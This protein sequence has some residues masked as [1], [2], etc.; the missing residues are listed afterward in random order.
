MIALGENNGIYLIFL[1][2]P[3]HFAFVFCVFESEFLSV[4]VLAVLELYVQLFL[5]PDYFLM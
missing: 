3:L 1:I 5:A 2:L 4:A